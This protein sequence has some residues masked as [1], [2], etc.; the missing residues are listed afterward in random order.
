MTVFS[1]GVEAGTREQG[2]AKLRF[3]VGFRVCRY[4]A[5]VGATGRAP[6]ISQRIAEHSPREALNFAVRVP[7]QAWD[8]ER[9]APGTSEVG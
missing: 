4:S 2:T 1:S 9:M 5:P 7:G 3:G 8:D 6:G